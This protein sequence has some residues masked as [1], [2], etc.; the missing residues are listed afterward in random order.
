MLILPSLFFLP[1]D[2]SCRGKKDDDTAPNRAGIISSLLC[3]LLP[4]ASG[5]P[6]AISE[7]D[8]KTVVAEVTEK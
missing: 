8:I 7:A 6:G 3:L 4:L 2:I 5:I 1:G